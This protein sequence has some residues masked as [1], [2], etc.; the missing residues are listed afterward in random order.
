MRRL[1]ARGGGLDSDGRLRERSRQGGVAPV[2]VIVMSVDV[3][4]AVE[5]QISVPG[6]LGPMRHMRVSS[7]CMRTELE[8]VVYTKDMSVAWMKKKRLAGCGDG[9]EA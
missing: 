2:F 6:G 9:V 7:T 5:L 3:A 1:A 8:L 4:M